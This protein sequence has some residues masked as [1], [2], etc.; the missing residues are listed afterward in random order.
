MKKPFDDSLAALKLIPDSF[1][2]SKMIKK[3]YAA[4]YADENTLYFNEDPD[5]VTFCCDEMG[6]N[7]SVNLNNINLDNN[8][9]EDNPDTI[10]LWAWHIKFEK[11]KALKNDK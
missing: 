7:N 1:V 5:D 8:F 6:L 10:R 4:L 2:T 3:I 9:D 11:C